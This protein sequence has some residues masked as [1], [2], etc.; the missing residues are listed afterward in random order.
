MYRL[1]DRLSNT[2]LSHLTPSLGVTPCEYVDEPYIAE[3]ID[4]V[5]IS[6]HHVSVRLSVTS[7]SC[8]ETAKPRIALSYSPGT[9]VFD[10]KNLGENP[11]TSPP[12]GAP[13]RGGVGSHRRFS[14]N[15]S[16]YLRNGA[17]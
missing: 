3:T 12:T 8:T 4:L 14:T 11:T 6:R 17:R 9:L 16:L 15:I 10:A 2:S 7:R 1:N 5:G 13:N